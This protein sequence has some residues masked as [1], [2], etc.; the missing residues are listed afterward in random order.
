MGSGF[1]DYSAGDVLT[2]S[3]VDGYLMRQTNMVFAS[4]SARD[5]A[6]S[7][8]LAEGMVAYL[9]DDD[10]FTFYT[11]AAWRYVGTPF[12]KIKGADTSVPDAST[13][14]LTLG[15]T[16]HDPLGWKSGNT[17]IPTVPGWYEVTGRAKG[18][19]TVGHRLS[20]A[21]YL[22]GAN[23]ADVSYATTALET[24]G[25]IVHHVE[26]DGS[27]DDISLAANQNSGGNIDVDGW[28]AIKWI[29]QS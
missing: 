2:A 19:F 17:L 6:L 22:N 18:S 14:V 3:D 9:S 20:I 8:V 16:D 28:L 25:M 13:T 23:S 1:K 21:I 11:G 7:G 29:G 12:A 24:A 10:L 15:T 4:A 27:T 26:L 5:T